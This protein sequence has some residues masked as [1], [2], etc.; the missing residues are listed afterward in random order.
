MLRLKEAVRG[1][2]ERRRRYE[3]EGTLLINKKKE[4]ES[5]LFRE[6]GRNGCS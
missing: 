5:D 3:R 6:L 4:T 2:T 1:H